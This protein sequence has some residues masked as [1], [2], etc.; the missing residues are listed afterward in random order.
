MIN[1]VIN[2]ADQRHTAE[3]YRLSSIYLGF[4]EA[5]GDSDEGFLVSGYSQEDYSEF[6]KNFEHFYVALVDERVIGFVFAYSCKEIGD[7]SLSEKISRFASGDC[8]LVKQVCVHP[9]FKGKGVGSKLYCHLRKLSPDS[10]LFAAIVVKPMNL[11]S[12]AF[13]EKAGF[14]KVFDFTPVD[15]IS[16]GMWKLGVEENV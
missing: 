14:K 7:K 6:L 10:D 4:D 3:I 12:A 2:K 16:R 15:G 8:L 5:N 13:H 11:S 1:I 9:G